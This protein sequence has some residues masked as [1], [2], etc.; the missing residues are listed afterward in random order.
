LA[1]GIGPR[2][3]DNVGAGGQAGAAAGN[4]GSGEARQDLMTDFSVQRVNMVESQ[5]RTSDVTDQRIVRAMLEVPRELFVPAEQASLAYMDDPVPVT[6]RPRTGDARR[7]LPPRTLAKLL[8]LLAVG[9]QSV[10]LDVGCATGYST[11]VLARLAERVVALEADRDLARAATAALAKLG[12]RNA[13]VAEGPL[14]G[15]APAH[16]RFDAIL[17]NGAVPSVPPALL[18]G[19]VDGGRLAAVLCRGPVSRAY[20]WRRSG[21]TIDSQPAFEAAAA[22]LPGFEEPAEFVF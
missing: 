7:L 6:A 22:P 5:V 2:A 3:A 17:L 13:V 18:N 8:Q 9:P 12:A 16:E 10:V 20:L 14:A 11:A 15:G 4:Q 21:S 1:A 19:L